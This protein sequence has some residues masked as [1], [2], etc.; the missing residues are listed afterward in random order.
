MSSLGAPVERLEI[1]RAEQEGQDST[2]IALLIEEL[3]PI[4]EA[5]WEQGDAGVP[6]R[7]G[8]WGQG[9]AGPIGSLCA[10]TSSSTP[11]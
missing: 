8:V 4:A 3:P 6:L 5:D 7:P 2:R 1:C 10:R 11:A 9:F